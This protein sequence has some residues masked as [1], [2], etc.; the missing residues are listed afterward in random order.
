MQ[1][2][3]GQA[4]SPETRFERAEEMYAALEDQRSAHSGADGYGVFISYRVAHSTKFADELYAAASKTQVR[5]RHC[6]A[7]LY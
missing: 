7:I 4:L 1:E 5:R 2:F 3:V 6:G